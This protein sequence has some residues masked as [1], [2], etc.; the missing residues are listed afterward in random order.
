MFARFD[1]V[2]SSEWSVW[3]VRPDREDMVRGGL[4]LDEAQKLL[5]GLRRF[6]RPG[7]TISLRES[8]GVG[9]DW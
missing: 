1:N 8:W 2:D 9:P 7:V 6:L 3:V 5:N 4:T